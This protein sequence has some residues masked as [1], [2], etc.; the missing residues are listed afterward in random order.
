[1]CHP[2]V[3]EGTPLPSVR[4]TETSVPVD[5]GAMPAL[6]AYP[7]R[8]PAGAVLVI[9]D[10]FGRSPFYD[11]LTRRIA[12]AG[13]VAVDPEYFWRVGAP[14][15]ASREAVNARVAK[16][17]WP[18]M[19]DDLGRAIDWM[20]GLR[21]ARADRIGLVGFCMGG[22][23]VLNLAATRDDL[24][25]PVSYYGFPA[26]GAPGVPPV[27]ERADAIRG[28]LIGHWGTEDT[29]VGIENVRA[30]DARLKAKGTPHTFY[31]YEGLGHGF[32][33]ASLEDEKTPG[34]EPACT[35]WKRTLAFWKERLAA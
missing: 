25:G 3:P 16:L 28:P 15:D 20:K 34:Y 10:V 4:A 18:K 11:D 29:G 12:Q 26:R 5:G 17:D 35:S 1:M 23:A 32:L 22:T 7:E 27:L 8:T 30:L 13:Y 14:A 33:K 9:N 21:E 6:I 31:E 2:E 24:R 19:Y